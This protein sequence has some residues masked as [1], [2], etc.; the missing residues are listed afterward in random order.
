MPNR[1]L[2]DGI[3][4]SEAVNMLSEEAEIFYRRLMSV[5]DDY[6]RFDAHPAILKARLFALR[7]EH[8]PNERIQKCLVECSQIEIEPGLPLLTV[9]SVGSRPYLQ[10]N[11]F[12]QRARTVSKFPAPGDMPVD[13]FGSRP[14]GSVYFVRAKKSRR[15]KI[16]FTQL[17]PRDRISSLQTGSAEELELIGSFPGTMADEREV[18]RVLSP[19][20]LGGEWFNGCPEVLDLCAARCAQKPA[21]VSAVRDVADLAGAGAHRASSPSPTTPPASN[22]VSFPEEEEPE[23]SL[24]AQE[25]PESPSHPVVIVDGCSELYR[26]AGVPVPPKHRQRILQYVLDIQPPER[27]LRIPRYIAWALQSGKWPHPGKTKAFLALM[28]DGD[29]D[30]EVTPRTLPEARA[31]PSK[32]ESAVEQVV[33]EMRDRDATEVR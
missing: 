15:I 14:E 18:H 17:D 26:Q 30:V 19:F 28:Q 24:A 6:G 22:V 23:V 9:Y 7:V 4:T 21:H 10:L 33:R 32:R 8:W 29:W 13:R 20:R 31:A 25:D 12:N 3:L 2:R 5:I 11:N 27:R 16:G 1:I